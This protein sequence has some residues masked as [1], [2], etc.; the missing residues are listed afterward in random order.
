M[1]WPQLRTSLCGVF[2]SRLPPPLHKH[3]DPRLWLLV[4]S[5]NMKQNATDSEWVAKTLSNVVF[6]LLTDLRHLKQKWLSN[7]P[8]RVLGCVQ[9]YSRFC[10]LCLRPV[11]YD[12]RAALPNDSS[13]SKTS[14]FH[15]LDYFFFLSR[16][17][18]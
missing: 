12:R 14:N 4:A 1:W 17:F 3:Q 13:S 2:S 6:S 15:I 16:S 8:C 11:S 5:S 7:G 18:T 10:V 9:Q